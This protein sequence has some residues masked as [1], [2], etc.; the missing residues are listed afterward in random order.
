MRKLNVWLWIVTLAL[1]LAATP[2]TVHAAPLYDE[3]AETAN[4]FADPPRPH[5]VG[6]LVTIRI[7][8]NLSTAK[9]DTLTNDRSVANNS[10]TGGGILSFLSSIIGN[11]GFGISQQQNERTVRS[12]VVATIMPCTVTAVLPNGYLQVEG[13]RDVKVNKDKLNLVV[14]GVVRPRDLD[15]DAGVDSSRVAE[16]QMVVKRQVGRGI[17]DSLIKILF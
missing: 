10:G 12:D 4:L 9:I 15:R 1:G 3:R 5:S 8:E 6:D 13:N 2:L 14:S 17:L 11:N 16:L 7:S